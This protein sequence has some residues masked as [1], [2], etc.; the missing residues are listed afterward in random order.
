MIVRLK[1]VENITAHIVLFLGLYRFF[2]ILHWVYNWNDIVLA[3]FLAGV[4]Q[5]FL[6]AD[7]IYYFIKSNQNDR[8]INLPIWYITFDLLFPSYQRIDKI[9]K[10]KYQKALANMA[11][12]TFSIGSSPAA[13]ASGWEASSKLESSWVIYWSS[14]KE[15]FFFSWRNGAIL[16]AVKVWCKSPSNKLSISFYGVGSNLSSLPVWKVT[17]L[18]TI[19]CWFFRLG[20]D[21]VFWT[22]LSRVIFI[23]FRL[24]MVKFLTASRWEKRYFL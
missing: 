13:K 10:H 23:I 8:I 12:S 9:F 7:F 1:E 6:Y 17:V 24:F 4:V 22:V 21:L 15:S 14:S 18:L 11:L 3:S 16:E 2:Y 19:F 20:M 5:T